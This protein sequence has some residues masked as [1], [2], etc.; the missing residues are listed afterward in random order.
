MVPVHCPGPVSRRR[1]LQIGAMSLGLGAIQPYQLQSAQARSEPATSVILI[2]LPGGPP[3]METYDMKPGAP[4]EYRGDFRPIKTTVPGMEV[5]EHLPMHAKTAKRF[6][7]I[8]SIS[9][10]FADHG[11]GHKK[12]LTGRD[13][14]Q[15]TGFVNDFPMVGSMV[16]KLRHGRGAGVPDYVLGAEPGRDQIDVY[17]FG[18]A[19]LSTATHPF[20]VPGDPSLSTFQ[21]RN[22]VHSSDARDRLSKRVELLAGLEAKVPG[23]PASAAATDDLRKQALTL[24]T[25]DRARIAFD[26]TRESPRV[27][28][29]YGLHCWGQRALLARRLVEAGSSFVTMGIERPD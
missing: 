29:R 19:Y 4:A 12:F 22:L 2:W 15:P 7:L 24:M 1:F 3:H 25:S 17:S 11:G 14:L 13:P 6:S 23:L 18:S 26:L 9:H 10:N 16:A 21:V 27:R 20:S 8:R 28:E 5:C